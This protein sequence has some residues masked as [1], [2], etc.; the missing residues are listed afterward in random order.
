MSL[1]S[2]LIHFSKLCCSHD[3]VA[4]TDGNISVRTRENYILTT[5]TELKLHEFIYRSRE[6]INTVVHTHPKFSSVF[7]SVGITLD[8]PVFPEIYLK[9]GKIPPV[10]YATPS[11]DEVPVSISKLLMAIMQYCL[12]ITDWL[13]TAKHFR[14]QNFLRKKLSS[15][16]K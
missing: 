15:L 1:K 12:L 6:D 2:E 10:K 13:N 16:Q 8:K 5:A 7:A 11:K 14:K 9:P 3:F 4:A